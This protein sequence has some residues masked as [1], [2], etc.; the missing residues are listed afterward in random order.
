MQTPI[1]ERVVEAFAGRVES[2]YRSYSVPFSRARRT[3]GDKAHVVMWAAVDSDIESTYKQ[4]KATIEIALEYREPVEDFECVERQANT[5]MA[6]LIQSSRKSTDPTL[7]G[8]AL[9]IQY[10]GAEI[11]YPQPG[12]SILGVAVII[13]IRYQFKTDDPF[14]Q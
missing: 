4:T 14:S 13:S 6:Q 10:A 2:F 9:S 1:R 7:G 8:L 12:S 5:I 11:E 3:T